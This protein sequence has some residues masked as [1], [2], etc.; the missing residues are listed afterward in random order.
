[1]EERQGNPAIT[2]LLLR[3]KTGDPAALRDLLPVV[4]QQLR[5][6]AEA[7]LRRERPDHTLQATE[8]V[9]ELYMRL[10]KQREAN[11][12]SRKQFF[13]F[14]ARLMRFILIDH[15]RSHIARGGTQRAPLHEEIAW[16]NVRSQDMMALDRALEELEA[17]D[18]AKVELLELR[19]FLGLTVE[20]AAQQ[21]G[22]S[23]ATAFRQ[24]TFIKAWLFERL[25]NLN[26]TRP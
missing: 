3:W 16:I 11:F 6:V 13:V 22:I 9:H 21:M 2:D 18:R 10:D 25:K 4:Y 5:A 14:A 17:L 20:E 19:Y 7:Y 23:R 24:L 8:L 26:E 1:M 12:A 15:A